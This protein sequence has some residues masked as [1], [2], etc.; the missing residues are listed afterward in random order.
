MRSMTGFGAAS[1]DRAG[2]SL[3]AEVRTVNHKHLQV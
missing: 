1:L 2:V 3:T